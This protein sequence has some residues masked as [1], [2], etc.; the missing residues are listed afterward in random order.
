MDSLVLNT[1]CLNVH[2]NTNLI[3]LCLFPQNKY[4]RWPNTL[5]QKPDTC[6]VS[7]L[8]ANGSVQ[9]DD[10]SVNHGVLRQRRHQV[11]KLS[12]VS[13]ARREGH[14][15]SEKGAHL[16]RETSQE[17]SGEQTW[18]NNVRVELSDQASRTGI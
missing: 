16:L 3:K 9:S 14:L 15:A 8:H 2:T 18:R 1:L 5:A 7:G 13:Q 17:G 12:G 10:L 11:G 4:T 6:S